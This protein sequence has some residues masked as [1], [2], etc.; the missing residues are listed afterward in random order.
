MDDA[1]VGILHVSQ[2]IPTRSNLDVSMKRPTSIQVHVSAVGP[3]F[4]SLSWKLD[5]DPEENEIDV[6]QRIPDKHSKLSCKPSCLKKGR[7]LEQQKS[8]KSRTSPRKLSVKR[9]M[10][11]KRITSR[12]QR[13]NQNRKRG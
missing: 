4:S 2:N 11:R 5:G 9:K 13:R 7:S 12:Q 3:R 10:K 1:M 8:K 6:G